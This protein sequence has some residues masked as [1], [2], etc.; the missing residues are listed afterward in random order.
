MEA[1]KWTSTTPTKPGWYWKR[2]ET[3]T[4]SPELETS[5]VHIR[6]YAGELC[7]GNCPIEAR[8]NSGP[9]EWAGPIEEPK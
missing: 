4:S 1:L 8:V 5:I 7:I 9:V 2:H 3:W 6:D